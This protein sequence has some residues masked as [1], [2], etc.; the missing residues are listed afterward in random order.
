MTLWSASVHVRIWALS[1]KWYVCFVPFIIKMSLEYIST[2]DCKTLN[3]KIK[4]YRCVFFTTLLSSLGWVGFKSNT[5]WLNFDF[6]LDPGTKWYQNSSRPTIMIRIFSHYS[7]TCNVQCVDLPTY[8][9][10][11]TTL[12]MYEFLLYIVTHYDMTQN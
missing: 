4:Y 9:Q 5:I 2:N 3:S 11:P 10:A 8:T 6:L 1:N 7:L 12:H